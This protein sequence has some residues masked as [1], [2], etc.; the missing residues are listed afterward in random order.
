LLCSKKLPKD[1]VK[2]GHFEVTQFSWLCYDEMYYF[3]N[4]QKMLTSKDQCPLRD[5]S[6]RVLSDIER[7]IRL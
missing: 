3:H 5:E 7:R 2:K 4:I 1:T 6:E